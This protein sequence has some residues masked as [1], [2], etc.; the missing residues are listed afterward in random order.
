MP[1]SKL[2]QQTHGTE[3]ARLGSAQ[4]MFPPRCRACSPPLGPTPP[5]SAKPT[6]ARCFPNQNLEACSWFAA[7]IISEAG[8]DARGEN[9]QKPASCEATADTSGTKSGSSRLRQTSPCPAL[10][11]RASEAP[12]PL[13]ALAH[14]LVSSQQAQAPQRRPAPRSS[15]CCIPEAVVRPPAPHPTP[16][17]GPPTS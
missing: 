11:C 15:T 1:A 16:T 6:A 9:Q 14:R 3:E 4:V 13:V 12:G 8:P 7:H 17:P 5:R 10:P 2:K